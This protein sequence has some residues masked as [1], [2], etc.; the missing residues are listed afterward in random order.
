MEL[1][2]VQFELPTG[3][4][5]AVGDAGVVGATTG[6]SVGLLVSVSLGVVVVVSVVVGVGVVVVVRV[7]V[8]TLVRGTQV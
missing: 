7:C 4:F 3:V 5:A 2:A 8:R 6:D 1:G